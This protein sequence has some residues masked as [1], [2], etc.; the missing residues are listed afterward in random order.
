VTVFMFRL[1]FLN[2]VPLF[3]RPNRYWRSRDSL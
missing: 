2:R 1:F 3:Y